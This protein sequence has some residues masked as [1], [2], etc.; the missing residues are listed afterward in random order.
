MV[1]SF[2]A[3]IRVGLVVVSLAAGPAAVRAAGWETIDGCRLLTDRYFDGDS[4][5]VRGGGRQNIFRL[6]AVDAP[7]TDRNFPQRVKDQSRYF[8]VSQK[9]VLEGGERAKELVASLMGQPFTVETKWTDARGGSGR[10]RYFAKITL[11]DGSDLATR[12]IEAGLARNFG[13][14]E[15]MSAAYL[16]RLAKADEAARARKVGLWGEWGRPAPQGRSATTGVP[17]EGPKRNEDKPESAG[18]ETPSI[19]DRLQRESEEGL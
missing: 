2:A 5:E 19:F 3:I 6:Y 13:M 14:R 18:S 8:K 12:L 17:K 15:G 16:S 1:S 9:V 7:E 10:T 4:F 11:S